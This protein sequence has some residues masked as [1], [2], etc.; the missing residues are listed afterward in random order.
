MADAT[1]HSSVISWPSAVRGGPAAL[2]RP[3][4]RVARV[5]RAAA[6]WR[7]DGSTVSCPAPA[8]STARWPAGAASTCGS[9][10]ASIGRPRPR[11]MIAT[12]ELAPPATD[13][14]PASPASANRIR[15]TGSTSR[16]TRM[17]RP[18]AGGGAEPP[19]S[20][21]STAL[22]IWR[23]SSARAARS[24][25]ASPDGAATWAAADRST[26]AAAL[27]PFLAAAH[28]RVPPARDRPRS[29]R[30][31]PRCPPRRRAR[32]PAAARPVRCAPL[33]RRRR[34]PP[35]PPGWRSVSRG[36]M[37]AG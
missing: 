21:A 11:A 35:P 17:N 22:A 28:R 27:V 29:A 14:A 1:L 4:A 8:S 16:R 25:L 18:A 31:W 36:R 7:G 13:T 37:S 10:P 2:A 19:A 24:G 3:F 6:S 30:R 23:T 15:S 12:W 32:P 33:P 5:A 9:T 20:R 34:R 26:A